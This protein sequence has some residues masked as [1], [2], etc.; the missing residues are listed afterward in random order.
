V[1]DDDSKSLAEAGTFGVEI[2]FKAEN[3]KKE[4]F[5]EELSQFLMSIAKDVESRKGGLIG[6]VKAFARVDEGF[7]RFNIVDSELGIDIGDEIKSKHVTGGTIKVMAA[8]VG[9]DD[10]HVEEIIEKRIEDL[11]KAMDID[12][13]EHEDHDHCHEEGE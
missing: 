6:H 5:I 8:V 11:R 10:H 13:A 4:R 12:V 2:A 7:I 9:V 1:N 3:M